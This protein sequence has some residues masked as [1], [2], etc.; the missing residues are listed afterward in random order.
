M[1]C[2]QVSIALTEMAWAAG[3][4]PAHIALPQCDIVRDEGLAFA[5]ALERAG[6]QVQS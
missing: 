1:C 2:R 5:R 3:L 4:P 6:N